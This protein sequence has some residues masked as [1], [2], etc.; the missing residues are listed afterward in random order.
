MTWKNLRVFALLPALLAT[1]CAHLKGVVVD[2]GGARPVPTAV[3][4][5]GR[6]DGIGVFESHKV[7]QYGKFDFKISTLDVHDVYVYDSATGPAA[8]IHLA[9]S[10]FG[11]KMK[12]RLPRV[13]KAETPMP[14]PR[15]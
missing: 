10:E 11:E 4:T 9:E 8:S 7:D 6:P 3:L 5:V 15:D 2:E 1:G 13:P 14:I 12:I